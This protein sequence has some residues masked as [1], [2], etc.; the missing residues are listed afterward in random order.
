MRLR[1]SVRVDDL[2]VRVVVTLRISGFRVAN[3]SFECIVNNGW[4][5]G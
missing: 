5:I 3:H 4:K 2:P 1:V